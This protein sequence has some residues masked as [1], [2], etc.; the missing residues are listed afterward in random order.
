MS[1]LPKF[2]CVQNAQ[3]FSVYFNHLCKFPSGSQVNV[4]MSQPNITAGNMIIKLRNDPVRK[5]V[6]RKMSS[7][8]EH[9]FKWSLTGSMI[10]MH[11]WSHS[12]KLM[13]PIIDVAPGLKTLLPPNEYVV[14]PSGTVFVDE[15]DTLQ[16]V[17]PDVH[18]IKP[19]PTGRTIKELPSHIS[20]LVLADSISKNEECVISSDQITMENGI[21]TGCGHVFSKDALFNWLSTPNAKGECPVCKNHILF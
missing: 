16:Y 4:L 17:E 10:D 6:I 2:F 13:C 3:G 9:N 7:Q 14:N 8:D 15:Q 21:V 5:C 18:V 12:T 20:K 19:K 1:F 11:L